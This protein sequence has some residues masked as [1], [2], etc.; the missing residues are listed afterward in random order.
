MTKLIPCWA[1][2]KE[3][4]YYARLAMTPSG[5]V[6][7]LKCPIHPIETAE[8]NNPFDCADEWNLK[9]NEYENTV[10]N[11]GSRCLA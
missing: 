2:G 11:G 8:K 3:P 5:S 1:C 10:G 7:K 4:I 6:T 9:M